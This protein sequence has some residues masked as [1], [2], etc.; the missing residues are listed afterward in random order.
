LAVPVVALFVG[1]ASG[2]LGAATDTLDT[3]SEPHINLAAPF[4][5][6]KLDVEM[7]VQNWVLCAS[8][9]S[10]EEIAQA[11]VKSAAEAQKAYAQLK[12]AKSCGQFPELRVILQQP[13]YSSAPDSGYDVRVFGG[14]V[15]FSGA[16][17][18]GFLI[19]GG[20]AE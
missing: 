1:T 12:A 5:D 20:V 19:S 11:R 14:L 10:A 4:T 17:A 3:P 16:W 6:Y 8:Q 2:A 15:K 13:V 7:I 9:P 18:S